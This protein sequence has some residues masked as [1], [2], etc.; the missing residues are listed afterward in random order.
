MNVEL[1][2]RLHRDEAFAK[3]FTAPKYT[4][5]VAMP[6]AKTAEYDADEIYRLL[7]EQVHVRANQLG[8]EAGLAKTFTPLQ[9]VSE[10]DGTATIVT[11]SIATRILE[12]H[13]FVGDLTGNNPGAVLETGAA[14]ALKP[15]HRLV[16]LTQGGHR[17]LHFD[18][19]VTFVNGYT[20]AT[21]VEDVAKGLVGAATAFE[22][23]T[24]LFITEVSASLTS[25]AILLLNRYGVLWANRAPHTAPSLHEDPA[26]CGERFA[27]A[28]GK[29]R[30]QQAIRELLHKRLLWTDYEANAVPGGDAY[31]AH[32]TKLGWRVIEN[33]W[34]NNAKMK[35][36][37]DSRTGP[38]P[39]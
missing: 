8:K 37:E 25:D 30:F 39:R 38:T 35:E 10:N 15:N 32:A 28:D 20:A 26:S 23:E 22:A 17:D 24:K 9:R 18:V 12:D 2:Y 33:I 4:T 36:P 6:F 34:H 3:Q 29:L 21:L 27:G 11:D 13:F 31:G 7:K 1:I 16:L 19:K 5:F 14:L